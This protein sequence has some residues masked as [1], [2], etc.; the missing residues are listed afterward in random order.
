MVNVG[1]SFE[2]S[3]SGFDKRLM[4]FGFDHFGVERAGLI[5]GMAQAVHCFSDFII[6][7]GILRIGANVNKV[8]LADEGKIDKLGAFLCSHDVNVV[9]NDF[10]KFFGGEVTTVG[11]IIGESESFVADEY[12][13]M[14]VIRVERLELF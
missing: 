11:I 4:I 3:F 14:Q 6:Q 10:N 12:A 1:E 9:R 5:P 8:H 2:Y 13:F 7:C